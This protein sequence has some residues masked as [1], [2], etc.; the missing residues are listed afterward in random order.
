MSS[1]NKAILV[2]NLGKDPE[3]RDLNN[4]G[5]VVSFSLATSESWTK[6]GERQQKTEWH[7][8]VIFDD[9]L[10]DFA[11]EKLTKG[12]KVYLEGK[13][14]T[15]KWQDKDGNDR[16]TTEIV[17]QR[18]Q[19]VLQVLDWG[20]K[21]E[22]DGGRRSSGRSDDR[23]G[24]GREERGGGGRGWDNDRGGRGNGGGREERGRSNGSGRGRANDDLDDDIPFAR[25]TEWDRFDQAL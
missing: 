19:G 11:E 14:Q 10:A 22:D 21:G 17:L 12:M 3:S 18:F 1:V 4:G 2:G 9:R 23:R 16:Y 13:I 6:D 20:E 25:S 8:V 5:K 15:R 24:G 7:N